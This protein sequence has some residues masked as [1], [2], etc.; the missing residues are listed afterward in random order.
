MLISVLFP[1]DGLKSAFGNLTV[2]QI[3]PDARRISFF[4]KLPE[5]LVFALR[6]Q[7]R[8]QVRFVTEQ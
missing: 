6:L 3:V 2:S 8:L 1:V 7:L 5:L 4:Q